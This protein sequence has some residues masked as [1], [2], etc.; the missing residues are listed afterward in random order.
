MDDSKRI[1]EMATIFDPEIPESDIQNRID[2]I[3]NLVSNQGGTVVKTDV[4]G[5]RDLAYPI[6]KRESGY[7]VFYYFDAAPDTPH[8]V[9]DQLRLREDILRH[10]IVIGENLPSFD[11][12]VDSDGIREE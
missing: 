10:M 1:Y 9:R 6:R 4:W 2:D 12:E 3:A 5:M 7:Y 8:K 11:E